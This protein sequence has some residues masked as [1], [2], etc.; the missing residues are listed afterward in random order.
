MKK[1]RFAVRLVEIEIE[2]G[3]EVGRPYADAIDVE[4]EPQV[5]ISEDT[6]DQIWDHLLNNSDLMA[7]T[8]PGQIRTAVRDYRE[9][10]GLPQTA[11]TG[12]WV[13][14]TTETMEGEPGPGTQLPAGEGSTPAEPIQPPSDKPDP[15]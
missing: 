13:Q 11:A 3:L 6:K 2:T 10:L 15:A 8:N 5:G 9:K 4:Y 7:E 1:K 14:G 12:H